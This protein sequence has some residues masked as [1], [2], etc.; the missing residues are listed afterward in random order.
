MKKCSSCGRE[1][2]SSGEKTVEITLNNKTKIYC[3][4]CQQKSEV[5]AEI[6]AV[7]GKINKILLF[8]IIGLAVVLVLI[9]GGVIW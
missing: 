2:K 5:Q 4:E 6:K 8:S 1:I 7:K 9:I 3:S